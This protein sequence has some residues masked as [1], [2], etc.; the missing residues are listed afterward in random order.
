V[1]GLL[2]VITVVSVAVSR[3]HLSTFGL[4][5]SVQLRFEAENVDDTLYYALVVSGADKHHWYDIP[6][7]R[8]RHV[9]LRPGIANDA[10]ITLFYQ[11]ESDGETLIWEAPDIMTNFDSELRIVVDSTGDVFVVDEMLVRDSMS[12]D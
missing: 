7:G 6:A 12:H 1:V 5:V 8:K 9:K 11:L 2:V 4:H 3:W 10:G